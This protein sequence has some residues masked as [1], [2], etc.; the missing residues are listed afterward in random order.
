MAIAAHKEN[1][2]G[3]RLRNEFEH[4][5]PFSREIAPHFPAV[6]VGNKLNA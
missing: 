1:A 5:L 4:A 2:I 3:V 6:L